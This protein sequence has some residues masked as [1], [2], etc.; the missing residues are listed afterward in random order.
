[1]SLE[2]A[3]YILGIVVMSLSL[4]ILLVLVTAVIVIR[5]KV[6][7]LQSFI[8]ERLNFFNAAGEVA[9]KVTKKR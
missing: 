9:K 7:H 4:I 2:D 3:F 5:N 6:V 1:M 8:E